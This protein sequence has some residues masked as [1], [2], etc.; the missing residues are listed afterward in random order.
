[1]G[2]HR[3]L[4]R[5]PTQVSPEHNFEASPLRRF[6]LRVPVG[7]VLKLPIAAGRI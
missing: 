3:D 4:G 7:S 1:M 6:E 5:G 2:G